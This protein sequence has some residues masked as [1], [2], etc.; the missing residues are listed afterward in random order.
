MPYK[1]IQEQEPKKDS[2]GIETSYRIPALASS[3][4]AA[5]AAGM[6]GDIAKTVNDLIAAPLTKHVFGQEPVPYEQTH[7]GKILPTTAQ[8]Q[9]TLEENI[10]FL[11][12]KNKL[13][14]FFQDIAKDA[15]SL[16]LPGKI[17]KMGRYAMTP[18]RSLG[19]STAAN[20]AGA[21]TGLWTGDK[22]KGDMVKGGSMIALSLFNPTSAKNISQN[23]YQSANNI[24]PANATVS[25]ANQ[26]SRLNDLERKILQ[27]RQAG[28]AAPSEKFVLDE[29]DKFKNLEK[30]GQINMRS[31]VAQNRSFNE[32]RS[33]KIFELTDRASKARAKELA[34]EISHIT[35]D[36]MKQYGKQN[37]KWL[38]Y[39][40]AADKAHSAIAQSN[41]ISRLLEKFMKG[42]PEAL[43]HIFGIGIPAGT[44]YFTPIGASGGLAAYQA[45]KIGT[46]II[47][48][49]ELR[50]HYS[51]VLGA[52]AADN[53]KLV[54]KEL[55]EL[56][57]KIEKDQPTPKS[58]Y[59][60]VQK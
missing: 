5:T 49:P 48:S 51:K 40:E 10:S 7:L 4:I 53:A 37:P 31:L 27:G 33:K 28:N 44:A 39:Q 35:K 32:E 59:R 11:K 17:F 42:R 2:I 8:H 47:K 18:L 55:D 43:A 56:E 21:G 23:L 12:P 46:R 58:R 16:Y 24:L 50:N 15:A 52:A 1:T 19:I 14:R 54:N 20:V 30:N 9:K 45:A 25:S 36:T 34:H 41:Y 13:E 22:S 6:F 38:E 26:I 3:G 29:I 57:D 60:I